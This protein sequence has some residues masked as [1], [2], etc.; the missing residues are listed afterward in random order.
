MKITKHGEELILAGTPP[1]VGDKAPDFS[2]VNLKKQIIQLSDLLGRPVLISV[3]PDIDTRVCALQT[4][5]FN[6]EAAKI[7]EVTFL[8]ISNNSRED[9][10]DWCAAE[11]VDMQ[12]LHDTELKFGQSFGLYIPEIDHLA[13]AIFIL[14]K[15]GIIVYEEIVPELSQEPDYDQALEVIKNL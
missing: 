7:S 6:Q 15:E 12:M 9:Q 5:R 3:V 2:I 1:K 11:G 10:L 14:N 4:K 13:R 8:T